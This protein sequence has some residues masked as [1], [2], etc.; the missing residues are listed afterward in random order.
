M[1]K[2]VFP[3]LA[4]FCLATAA[5]AQTFDEA[6]RINL[7]LGLQL[8]TQRFARVEDRANSFRTAGFGER[9]DRATV[10]S[11]TTHYFT[12]PANTVRVELYY[13]E[14]PE[15]CI[16]STIHL[17]VSGASQVLDA[18]MPRLYPGYVRKVTQGPVN[19]A[20]GM[21]AIC[22]RY[23]DP[24]NP[25]GEVIGVISADGSQSCVESG[26]SEIFS[27]SRV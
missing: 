23:E 7:L 13:G 5:P 18:A 3:L 26:T 11:D 1:T 10:N 14:M 17:G 19:P 21:P 15:H 9:V 24:T 22:V 2:R 20:T 4:A 27:A 8:C 6:V 16:V 12:A 25:I